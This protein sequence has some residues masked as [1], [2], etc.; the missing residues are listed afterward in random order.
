MPF[1][2]SSNRVSNSDEGHRCKFLWPLLSSSLSY[3]DRENSISHAKKVD[4]LINI[5][6]VCCAGFADVSMWASWLQIWE[7]LCMR[8]YICAA[9]VLVQYHGIL[10]KSTSNFGRWC[11]CMN[12]PFLQG[13]NL[14]GK[15]INLTLYWNVMPVTGGLRMEKQTLSGFRLP[16]EYFRS[17][18]SNLV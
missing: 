9:Y 14:L 8:M 6:D 15:D 16:Q 4:N 13:N 17:W 18:R 3:T 1:S 12:R 11:S 5:R 2:I 10:T 7:K